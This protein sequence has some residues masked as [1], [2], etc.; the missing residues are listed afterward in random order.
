MPMSAPRPCRRVG[1]P[2]LV[3]DRS[4]YCEAHRREQ[5]RN[6]DARKPKWHSLYKTARWQRL[7]MEQLVASPLCERCGAVAE[8]AHHRVPHGGD[9]GMFYSMS[10]LESLCNRCHER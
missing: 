1:C 8:V 5:R 3:T 9:P 10:N 6:E 2:E 4:G 7:R